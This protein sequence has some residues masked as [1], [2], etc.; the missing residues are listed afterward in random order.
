MP[1]PQEL[2]MEDVLADMTR[3]VLYVMDRQWE[4]VQYSMT[5]HR[6]MGGPNG[7][8][9]SGDKALGEADYFRRHGSEYSSAEEDLRNA[10]TNAFHKFAEEKAADAHAKSLEDVQSL[11]R[12]VT[13]DMGRA[14][15]R[16]T[17]QSRD[18]Q[19]FESQ[20][21]IVRVESSNNDEAK[22]EQNSGE[23]KRKKTRN[24]AKK[25]DEDQHQSGSSELLVARGGA[26]GNGRKGRKKEN[27]NRQHSR[28][29]GGDKSYSDNV[30]E[31]EE[32][33]GDLIGGV[34]NRGSVD[35]GEGGSDASST[36]LVLS[37]QTSPM[38]SGDDEVLAV[39]LDTV[40][41]TLVAK[42][43]LQATH[44]QAAIANLV[45]YVTDR[46]RMDMS[47]MIRGKFNTFLLLSFHEEL[48]SY[49]RR[50]LDAYLA[51]LD[52]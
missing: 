27:N 14:R 50:E 44:T 40:S 29:K 25:N 20:I 19:G 33:M 38:C 43:E 5:L 6:P 35:S 26:V 15:K 46:M 51:S 24:S 22:Q 2:V 4:M 21:E 37:S 36:S 42:S 7:L 3:R 23:T 45:H 48:G 30:M 9:K 41:S 8:G 17:N 11:L 28:S 39:L 34:M 13:W 16:E 52:P 31:N 32:D 12:Y 10:L 1:F 47:R 49:L 18:S